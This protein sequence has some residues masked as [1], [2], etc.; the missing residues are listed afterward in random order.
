MKQGKRGN[1]I[2]MSVDDDDCDSSALSLVEKATF[3]VV[4]FCLCPPFPVRPIEIERRK[5]IFQRP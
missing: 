4:V 3:V 1:E 5:R 2:K